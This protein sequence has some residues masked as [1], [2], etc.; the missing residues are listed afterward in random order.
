MWSYRLPKFE[1]IRGVTPERLPLLVRLSY[2]QRKIMFCTPF[3]SVDVPN[4]HFM[5]IFY[6]QN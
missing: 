2:I 6:I 5:H 4:M 1:A 3:L